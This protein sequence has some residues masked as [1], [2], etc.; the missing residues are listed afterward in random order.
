MAS[1]LLLVYDAEDPGCRRLVDRVGNCDR[2]GRVVTF[3]HLNAELVRMAGQL[4]CH[5]RALRAELH[6]LPQLALPC[7]LHWDLNHF[8]V[9]KSVALRTGSEE[10][11]RSARFWGRWASACC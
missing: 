1:T 3:P 9:L 10:W 6:H 4:Q 7:V 8:V 5:A 2:D 11:D